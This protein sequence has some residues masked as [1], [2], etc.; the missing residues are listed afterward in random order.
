MPDFSKMKL[1]KKPKK[2]DPRTLQLL[3]YLTSKVRLSMVKPT[4]PV[5]KA[6]DW[7]SKVPS[8]PMYGN[9]VYGDCAIAAIGHMIQMWSANAGNPVTP[10][11]EEILRVYKILS[12]DDDGCVL[13]DVLNWWCKNPISGVKLGAYAEINPKHIGLSKVGMDIFGGLYTGIALPVVAQNQEVWHCLPKGQQKDNRVPG[14]WGGHCVPYGFYDDQFSSPGV[15][16]TIPGM[17]KCVTW[18]A[19]ME[20]TWLWYQFYCDECYALFSPDW[21]TKEGVTPEGIDMEHLK[22]DLAIVRS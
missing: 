17:T 19:T 7:L 5:K 9:D 4:I 8:F 21:F 22:A 2:E 3:S 12:P 15:G 10:T 14:S 20:T 1:G 6:V 11:D 18:G 13:L 16:Q